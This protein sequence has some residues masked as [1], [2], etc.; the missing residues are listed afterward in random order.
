MK[1]L[2]IQFLKDTKD[3]V[4]CLNCGFIDTVAGVRRDYTRMRGDG[5]GYGRCNKCGSEAFDFLK[6]SENGHEE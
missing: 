1:S 3:V 6:E 2:V 5:F 4:Q